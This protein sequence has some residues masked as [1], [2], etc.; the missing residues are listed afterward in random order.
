M[1][2]TMPKRKTKAVSRSKKVSSKSQ[3]SL[4]NR[5]FPHKHRPV[6]GMALGII[7]ILLRGVVGIFTV[8]GTLILI[9]SVVA[10]FLKTRNAK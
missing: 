2:N 1:M 6:H 7:L 3:N 4:I 5:Y 10:Y 9:L 8:L